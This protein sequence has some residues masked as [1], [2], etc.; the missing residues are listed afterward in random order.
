[1]TSGNRGEQEAP[2]RAA[3][4]PAPRGS[5]R[6]LSLVLSWENWG[7]GTRD[8]VPQSEIGGLPGLWRPLMS[9]AGVAG[10][11][12]ASAPDWFPFPSLPITAPLVNIQV[13]SAVCWGGKTE[14]APR[15]RSL[16][17]PTCVE[18]RFDLLKIC[19]IGGPTCFPWWKAEERDLSEGS[20]QGESRGSR[21]RPEGLGAEN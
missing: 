16:T 6:G 13:T 11:G 12:E 7:S 2:S 8:P 19:L 9:V 18:G 10:L 14:T 5:T 4:Q 3:P 21:V 15:P 20:G 1:M 17:V